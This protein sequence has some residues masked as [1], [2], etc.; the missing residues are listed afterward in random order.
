MGGSALFSWDFSLMT[1][2]HF[3]PPCRYLPLL[4]LFHLLSYPL[5]TSP[6]SPGSH[7]W[8]AFSCFPLYVVS[9]SA[10]TDISVRH[11][12]PNL[13][14]QHA[15]PKNL[16]LYRKLLINISFMHLKFNASRAGLTSSL[17]LGSTH[18]LRPSLFQACLLPW[19]SSLQMTQVT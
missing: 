6:L 16:K 14:F 5:P 13:Y 12:L 2:W 18:L 15:F 1:F 11:R 9:V 10:A 4:W 17:T 19:I 8:L 7:Y 3:L